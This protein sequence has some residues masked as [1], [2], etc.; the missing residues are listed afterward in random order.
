MVD[1]PTVH[2]LIAPISEGASDIFHAEGD[3]VFFTDTLQVLPS[4]E[5]EKLRIIGEGEAGF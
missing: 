4:A 5:P 1:R 3:S 2:R